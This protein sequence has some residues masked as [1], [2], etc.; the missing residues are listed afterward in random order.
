[1]QSNKCILLDITVLKTVEM[2][3]N[4]MTINK[5]DISKKFK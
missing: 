5:N 4:P 2:K 1:M 3:F